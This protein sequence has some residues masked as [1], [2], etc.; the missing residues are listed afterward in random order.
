MGTEQD[1][2]AENL[3][4]YEI[5]RGIEE[6]LSRADERDRRERTDQLRVRYSAMKGTRIA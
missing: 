3:R 4:K 5:R 6:I 1:R 2:S